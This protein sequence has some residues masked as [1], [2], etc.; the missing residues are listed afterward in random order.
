MVNEKI[1]RKEAIAKGQKVYWK[2]KPC[3]Q[4]H[5]GWTRVTGPCV[6]CQKKC[7]TNYKNKKK[8]ELAEKRRL[9][10]QSDAGKAV[11]NNYMENGGRERAAKRA[12]Q[13]RK[14][15]PDVREKEKISNKMYKEKN[16]KEIAEKRR[17][18]MSNPDTK[19]KAKQ[20]ADKWRTKNMDKLR[21]GRREYYRLYAANRRA[22]D[23]E[24]KVYT[25]MRDFVRRCVQAINGV[26][27]WR[28]KEVLGYTPSQL[29]SHMESL[30]QEGMSWENYGKWHID[31][32]KSIKAFRDEGV[33]DLKIINALTNLQ[34]LWAF[35]NL[36]K[37]A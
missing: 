5:V 15:K 21:E 37:G 19:I 27:N 22:T 33:D 25:R 35:D 13:R 29:K 36:S 24:Y 1:N 14:E 4:G 34:P 31:H 23:P 30:W 6:E 2:E 32:V 3:P 8:T 12:R 17:I 7:S 11:L 18:Y 9:Y 26:K 20:T 16:K 28:T 10:L